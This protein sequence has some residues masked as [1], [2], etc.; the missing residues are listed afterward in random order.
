MYTSNGAK[1]KLKEKI[2]DFSDKLTAY[3]WKITSLVAVLF[4][5]NKFKK[6]NKK[7]KG[8]VVN[9]LGQIVPVAKLGFRAKNN[10]KVN[11]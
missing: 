3:L 8:N 7:T 6:Y 9:D 5:Q 10:K 2:C 4:C 11:I 1:N